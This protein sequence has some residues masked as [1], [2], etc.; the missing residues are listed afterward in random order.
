[1]GR[2]SGG[3]VISSIDKAQPYWD[4]VALEW[5][6]T[7]PDSLWRKHSDRVNASLL[8]D[9]LSEGPAQRILKT[10]LFDEAAGDGLLSC[11]KA[12]AV[13]VVGMDISYH[14]LRTAGQ[15]DRV[16]ICAD[17]RSLP[18]TSDAFDVVV[19]NSTLDHFDSLEEIEISLRELRRVLRAGGQLLLTLD[20]KANPLI[21]L[22]NWLPSRWLTL[23]GIVPYYVGVTCGPSR[24]R[25]MLEHAGLEVAEM[26]AVLHCPRMAAVRLARE[27]QARTGARTHQRFL[28]WLMKWER[29]SAWPTRFLTGN[30]IAVRCVKRV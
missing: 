26:T 30:F 5:M 11:L 29:L 25:T 22:R 24:L 1:M 27:V 4:Q 21:A 28:L 6:R 2:S 13:R 8:A 18:F 23:S 10:D 15:S 17:V 3:F 20:N 7:R 14:I 16:A 12:R 9:W 19:S